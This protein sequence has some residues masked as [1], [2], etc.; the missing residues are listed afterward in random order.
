MKRFLHLVC[1][2]LLVQSAA[3]AQSFKFQYQGADVAD[4]AT[5]SIP[6]EVSIFGDL[7]C[8]TNPTAN[9][10][11]GLMLVSTSS[12]AVSGKARLEILE[13]TFRAKTVQWCMGVGCVPMNNVTTLDKDFSGEASQAINFDAFEIRQ[14]GYLLAKLTATVG[15]QT[16][17]VYIE[18][19][20]GQHSAVTTLA[21][22]QGVADI[23]DLS[24]NLVLRRADAE[25]RRN[26]RP[27]IYLVSDG[28]RVRKVNVK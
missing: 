4:G 18:F 15:N 2:F 20:N 26:L 17:T 13:H 6:A 8:E 27:G 10:T 24:G 19:T 23:Y 14:E 3:F 12:S 28:R 9:S 5:V 16:Q 21:D 1:A 11:T 7:A 22:A 25:A